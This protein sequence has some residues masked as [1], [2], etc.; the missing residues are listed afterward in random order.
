MLIKS[1]GHREISSSSLRISKSQGGC[2]TLRKLLCLLA[3]SGKDTNNQCCC[4]KWNIDFCLWGGIKSST[5]TSTHSWLAPGL[6]GSE[7]KYL[8]TYSICVMSVSKNVWCICAVLAYHSAKRKRKSVSRDLMAVC[9]RA[10]HAFWSKARCSV[11]FLQL[12]SFHVFWAYTP[13]CV[14]TLFYSCCTMGHPLQNPKG[15]FMSYHKCSPVGL[16]FWTRNLN[17][18]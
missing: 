4:R 1:E 15:P 13:T 7:Q 5:V 3:S 11:S 12:I 9:S 2:E 8:H 16:R 14:Q 10:T 6:S 18:G 17:A